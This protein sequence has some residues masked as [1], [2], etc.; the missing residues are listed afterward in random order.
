MSDSP[1]LASISILP[2]RAMFADVAAPKPVIRRPKARES[3]GIKFAA[4]RPT[5][6]KNDAPV[7]AE[8]PKRGRGRPR[9]IKPWEAAGVPKATWYRRQKAEGGK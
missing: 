9:T 6:A 5:V 2:R 8:Q 1:K 7:V 4:E 3:A